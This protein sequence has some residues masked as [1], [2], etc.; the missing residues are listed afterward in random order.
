MTIIINAGCKVVGVVL[1]LVGFSL[2]IEKYS[3]RQ[4]MKDGKIALKSLGWTFLG[5]IIASIGLSIFRFN[6]GV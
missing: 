4:R 2:M 1:I 5:F 3:R 6:W